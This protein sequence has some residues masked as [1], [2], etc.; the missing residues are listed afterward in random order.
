MIIQLEKGVN[1]ELAASVEKSFMPLST[2]RLAYRLS[3][4]ITLSV[5]GR[6]NLIFEK[7]V[8]WMGSRISMWFLMTISSY[9]PNGR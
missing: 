1:G 6:S 5:Q 2:R 9:L 3:T 4:V 8:T 7:L